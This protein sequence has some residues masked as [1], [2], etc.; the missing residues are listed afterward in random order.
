MAYAGSARGLVAA[1]KFDGA[2]PIAD[3]MAA[4]ISAAA[5]GSL[6]TPPRD[7]LSEREPAAGH[8]PSMPIPPPETGTLSLVP[9]PAH[10]AHARARGF[11][12]ARRLAEALSRRTGLPM[13]PCLHR[14][15]SKTS[16]LGLTRRARLRAGGIEIAAAGPVPAQPV[17][18][19]DVHTTGATLEAAARALK[20]AGAGRIAAVTYARTTR[21]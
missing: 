11:D 16:Q 10:P 15:G 5:P 21:A 18:V 17:L 13:D 3:L 6:L 19:D 14:A 1:L 12:Q 20:D 7:T 8:P 4:Q 9:I 2:L